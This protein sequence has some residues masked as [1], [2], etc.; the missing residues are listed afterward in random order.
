M[1]ME[2]F[3]SVTPTPDN[4]WRAIILFGRNV[5]SYKFALAQSLLDISSS[6]DDLVKLDDLAAPFSS[7]LCR[8]LK[9]ADK[10]ITSSKSTFLDACRQR[11][12][13]TITET[14]L[15]E[16]TVR[17]GFN[18]VIDAFHIVG[19]DEIGLRFFIDER[20]ENKGIR[21]TDNLYTLMGN[22]NHANILKETEA[23]WRLVETAWEL[24]V[25][26]T[27]I[28]HD[29][30]SGQLITYNNSRRKGV[31]S[32]RDALNGYQKGLCFYCFTPISVVSGDKHLADVDHFFPHMLKTLGTIKN[33]DGVWNLVL[34]CG[35]CNR[36]EGGKSDKIPAL[37]LVQRLAKRNE[38]LIKSHHPLK[39]TL[40]SQTGKTDLDRKQFLQRCLTI[41]AKTRIHTWDPLP[42]GLEVF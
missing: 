16:Q 37:H 14:Q 27:I 32:S 36:G 9:I 10:Q 25:A 7:H 23:R 13:G 35:E 21:L 4:Y 2:Q 26:R 41:A 22:N 20:R 40:I 31:T 34:A 29:D 8:H 5:A 3:Y 18:N 24:G 33:L 6:T 11:N 39:D 38:Y 1:E 15:I 30:E 17:L 42:R 12:A 19:Q 28:E